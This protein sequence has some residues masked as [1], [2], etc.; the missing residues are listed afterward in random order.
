[1]KKKLSHLVIGAL[2]YS[3]LPVMVQAQD[4]GCDAACEAAR[5]AANPLADIRAIM[6][7]NT[8]AFRTGTDEEDSYNFQIQPVYAVPLDGANLVLR[9]IIPIQG[10]APGAVLPPGIG[11]PTQNSDLEWGIGDSTVQAFYA[12]TPSGN[13]SLG[14]GLQ[15]SLPTHTDD[16]L[17][18]A[19][20]GAGPAFVMFGQAGDLSWGGVL[21]H[22]WG[23]SD[24]NTT[25]LQPIL[26]YG[27]GGGWYFG[28]NNVISYNWNAS[29]NDEAWLVPLGLTVGKTI[30]TNDEKGTAL[31]LSAG[32]YDVTQ[33]PTG[34]PNRQFKFGISFF[35]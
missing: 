2:T 7:D 6:T 31:D 25:I 27:L 4:A 12:P 17:Q 22:M 20:W 10:V 21:A 30:I 5:K 24:F 19:G 34:G 32:Y 23:E 18:G 35:F 1:M 33:S 8:V 3:F 28:Y 15:V 13:I 14:Y 9:G 29:N 11:E 26:I 16:A